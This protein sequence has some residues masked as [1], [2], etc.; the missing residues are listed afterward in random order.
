METYDEKLGKYLKFIDEYHKKGFIVG[1]RKGFEFANKWNDAYKDKPNK[2][3]DS[4]ISIPV[5]CKCLNIDHIKIANY[6]FKNNCWIE[7]FTSMPI[8]VINWK[9]L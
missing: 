6:D 2:I 7:A 3:I 1:F 9:N 8:N 4:N 5:L